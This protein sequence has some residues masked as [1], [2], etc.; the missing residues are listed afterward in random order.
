MLDQLAEFLIYVVVVWLPW[1]CMVSIALAV[2]VA[3]VLC[4]GVAQPLLRW[5]IFGVLVIAGLVGGLTWEA[6]RRGI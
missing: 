4:F 6:R 5:A 1:R 3:G 2:L